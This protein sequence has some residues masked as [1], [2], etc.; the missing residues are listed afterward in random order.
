MQA[1]RFIFNAKSVAKENIR[2]MHNSENHKQNSDSLFMTRITSFWRRT[3]ENKV[4]RT[5]ETETRNTEFLTVDEA[6]IKAILTL[7]YSR[8]DRS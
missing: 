7:I 3:G 5:R 1:G 2:V 6:C 4:E 8:R